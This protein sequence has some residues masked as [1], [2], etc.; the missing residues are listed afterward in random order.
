MH[1]CL[2]SFLGL[3]GSNLETRGVDMI[4]AIDKKVLKQAEKCPFDLKC[5]IC[6]KNTICCPENMMGRDVLF[7]KAKNNDLCPYK[8]PFGYS[9]VCLCPARKEIYRKYKK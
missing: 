1:N 7:I 6:K 3:P 9:H 5:Q 2:A 8:M 4:M